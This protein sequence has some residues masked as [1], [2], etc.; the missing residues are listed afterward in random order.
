MNIDKIFENPSNL[1]SFE[2]NNDV[3]KVFDDMVSRSVPGYH[4]IQDIISLTYD[5][6]S[7]NRVFIDVGCST[8]T[9]IAKIL[10][11]NQVNY[12]YGI[13]IS[14]SML[15]IAQEKC[16]EH[17]SLVT[18]KNCNLL[19]GTDNVINSEKVP[20]FIILNLV[21]QFIR[22]PERKKFI[23]NIKSLC[24]SS[25][26]MLVFE[27]II[28][29][30]AEINMKYIDSYLKWKGKNGYSESE[31]SNKRKALENKLIPYLHEENIEL[32]KSSGFNSVEICFSFLN[33]RGY[34]CRC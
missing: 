23:T 24:S 20:D 19:N 28:F 32:F 27:K 7:Q 26:L 2:F 14:E 17:E 10:S 34:L 22:P 1:R 29:N 15:A 31:V 21:L 5:E 12:C 3:C 33:F 11:E 6:F 16:G 30:D 18:F 9:T 13:D 25:T 4:N 8:G